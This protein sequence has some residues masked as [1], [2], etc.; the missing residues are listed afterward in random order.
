ML[1]HLRTHEL[2][3]LARVLTVPN[4][5]FTCERLNIS[6]LFKRSTRVVA[7]SY[8]R[9]ELGR[10]SLIMTKIGIRISTAPWPRQN[11]GIKEI[12]SYQLSRLKVRESRGFTLTYLDAFWFKTLGK[13]DFRHKSRGESSRSRSSATTPF[14]ISGATTSVRSGANRAPAR[15]HTHNGAFIVPWPS[16]TQSTQS[17][18]FGF[19]W[20]KSLSCVWRNEID[21]LSYIND[22]QYLNKV[23]Y[24]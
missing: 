17:T 7:S 11:V 10:R 4:N 2:T 16:P 14:R 24:S 23:L 21:L 9:D 8:R 15:R 3:C 6:S 13:V 22:S 18:Q 20:R 5:C 1:M 12:L 19:G